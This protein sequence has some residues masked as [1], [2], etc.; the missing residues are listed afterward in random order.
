PAVAA[1]GLAS[2]KIIRTDVARR[3]HLHDLITHFKQGAQRYGLPL[4]PSDTAIQPLAVGAS[5]KA[6][7]I[8]QALA[9]R[10]FL[11]SAIRPPTVPANS[12]RL[13]ITLSASHTVQQIDAL[14]AALSAALVL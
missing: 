13:R 11:V 1:A 10:G 7:Q 8:S 14:L 6:L 2:L 5:D 4:M 3:Q 9:E 12:A